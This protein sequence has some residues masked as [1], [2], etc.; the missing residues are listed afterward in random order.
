MPPYP[1]EMESAL[2]RPAIDE[3][4]FSDFSSQIYKLI[5][6]GHKMVM[7]DRSV[8]SKIDFLGF[9]KSLLDAIRIFRCDFHHLNAHKKNRRRPLGE[10]FHKLAGKSILSTPKLKTKFQIELLKWTSEVLAIEYQ[11]IK[12]KSQVYAD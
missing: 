2:K 9:G 5:V 7:D 12:E 4:T 11:F 10:L 6:D 8:I 3:I 1:R